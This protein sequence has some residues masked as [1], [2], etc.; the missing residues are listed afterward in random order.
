M[1]VPRL[2]DPELDLPG[3]DLLRR[4]SSHVHRDRAGLRGRHESTRSEYPPERPD[5]SHLVRGRD[6][7]VEVEP[8][9]LD[10]LHVVGSHEVG[11][12]TLGLLG[13]LSLSDHQ[14]PN[15]LSG[16]VRE[17]HGTTH[18]LIRLPGS[19]LSRR[20]HLD[21]LVEAGEGEILYQLQRLG[22]GNLTPRGT[23]SRASLYF[24]PCLG[25]ESEP[26]M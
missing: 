5:L 14:N 6:D 12:G 25:I 22:R 1:H 15:F 20:R 3:L 26:S 17:N 24:F 8:A 23:F 13:L 9:L 7:D 2:V 11:T 21:R 4:P 19:T 18:D 10:L 16:P